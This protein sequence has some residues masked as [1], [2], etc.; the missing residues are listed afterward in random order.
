MR[1]RVRLSVPPSAPSRCRFRSIDEVVCACERGVK[2]GKPRGEGRDA[3]V[4]GGRHSLRRPDVNPL[5]DGNIF[6]LVLGVLPFLSQDIVTSID[7]VKITTLLQFG[8][9]SFATHRV[10]KGMPPPP[11]SSVAEE[12]TDG[13]GAN[14]G[15]NNNVVVEGAAAVATDAVAMQG[16]TVTSYVR[17]ILRVIFFAKSQCN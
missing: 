6:S 12:S 17:R 7:L 5:A 13:G 10:E 16:A 14:V 3:P 1:R 2:G 4:Q 9:T 11:S 8:F 15:D